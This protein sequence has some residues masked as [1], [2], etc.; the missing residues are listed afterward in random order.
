MTLLDI[1]V[2]NIVV[3]NAGEDYPFTV[4]KGVANAEI[5][6]MQDTPAMK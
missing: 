2:V 4:N 6:P 3:V 5:A 1:V